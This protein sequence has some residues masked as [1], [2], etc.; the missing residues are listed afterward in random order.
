MYS[1]E[2]RPYSQLFFLALC[3][4]YLFLIAFRTGRAAAWWGF[5]G[6]SVL[7][8]YTH[9]YAVFEIAS[10][11]LFALIYH[12]RCEI[13]I[14][15]WIAGAGVVVAAFV[16]W[17]F[18][19]IIAAWLRAKKLSVGHKSFRV[20]DGIAALL[21]SVNRF[22]G[23][24]LLGIASSPPW[25]GILLGGIFFTVP[26]LIAC[27]DTLDYK[28]RESLAFLSIFC[29]L[30]LFVEVSI[31]QLLGVYDVRYVYFALIPY[32]LLVAHGILSINSRWARPALIVACILYSG[33]SL[34]ANYFI[35][36]KE[37]Y[38]SAYSY[39]R[40]AWQPSDCYAFGNVPKYSEWAWEIYHEE[41]LQ[42]ANP[43]ERTW[44]ITLAR[45]RN[46]I[47]MNNLTDARKKLE[48]SG[49]HRTAEKTYFAIYLD[50]YE[51][52][53]YGQLRFRDSESA[54]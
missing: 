51:S 40:Q 46:A 44:L 29:A 17:L 3:S 19:G 47:F 14:R 26:A 15:R 21:N 23:G 35:R 54:E 32:L 39:L 34:R 28:S 9:Y 31:G 18:N 5:V 24:K 27:I 52:K 2:A 1:Q 41:P 50:L 10:F 22:N 30:P 36:Y 38:H 45:E 20:S 16:P 7:A 12:D 43:C 42:N 4:A 48:D 25:W 13:R 33:A 11:V 37:D 49:L 6:V 8:L 53:P